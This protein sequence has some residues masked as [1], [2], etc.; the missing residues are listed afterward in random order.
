MH[1]IQFFSS[2][3]IHRF[4]VH[5]TPTIHLIF[6]KYQD[7]PGV[8]LRTGAALSRWIKCFIILFTVEFHQNRQPSW[9]VKVQTHMASNKLDL[10]KSGMIWGMA[11]NMYINDRACPRR[12]TWNSTR[13]L[14]LTHL[15]IIV[16]RH[17]SR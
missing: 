10:I 3:Y 9:Q 13:I 2:P 6:N 14:L 17:K 5:H 8:A 15:K 12:D 11:L 4:W 7:C 1:R 16:Y